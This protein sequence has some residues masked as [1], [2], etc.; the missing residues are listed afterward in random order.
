MKE[1]E[2]GDVEFAT[3]P[4]LVAG[5]ADSVEFFSAFDESQ[6]AADGGCRYVYID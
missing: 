1:K 4:T 6:K 5:E 2:A 3:R